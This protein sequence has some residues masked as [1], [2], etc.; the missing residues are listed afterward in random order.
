MPDRPFQ[1]FEISWEV[2]NK[3]GG[4]H[5]V[6]S[7]KA[8]TAVERFGDDY[9]TIGPQLIG[10]TGVQ[11]PFDAPSDAGP[12]PRRA[13][14]VPNRGPVELTVDYDKPVKL[15][16][17][18]VRGR[19]DD[20]A[21]RIQNANAATVTLSSDASWFR[22]G[23]KI[24]DGAFRIDDVTP[25]RFR[26]SLVENETTL[27]Y[28]DWFDLPESGDVD[29]GMVTTEPAGGLRVRIRRTAGTEEFDP[30]MYLQR[31]GAPTSTTVQLG[32]GNELLVENL[33]PGSY[34][35]RAY[36]K[37]MVSVKQK[38]TVAVATTS[39]LEIELRPAASGK[40]DV[41]WP[42][43]HKTSERRGY[44]ITDPDGNIGVEFEGPLHTASTQP[45]ELLYGLAA[46]RYRLE[47]WTD[48]GLR[49]ELDF[50][51]PRSLE[52][53]TLRLDLK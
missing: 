35:I 18:T 48:D 43:D 3:V 21:H 6:L 28:T 16:P 31:D 49:G 23:I 20:A 27:A 1:L 7:S 13:G 47:F 22:S 37:G 40:I 2:C 19:I 10:G 5:T 15:R 4:I 50:T 44:R 25:C 36:F 52:P 32:R 41:W 9:I 45:Y 12:A 30:K 24:E 38:A 26:I 17:G 34:S 39:D 29:V 53:P 14:I 42:E 8:V 33:S 51:I 46:G 11:P